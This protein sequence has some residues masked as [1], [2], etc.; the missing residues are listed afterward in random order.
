MPT[1]ICSEGRR[2]VEAGDGRAG[3]CDRSVQRRSMI[4][5]PLAVLSAPA[6]PAAQARGRLQLRQRAGARG[7][8]QR[9]SARPAQTPGP[10]GG[11]RRRLPWRPTC[12]SA[13]RSDAEEQWR[14]MAL[15]GPSYL[16]PTPPTRVERLPGRSWSEVQCQLKLVAVRG[17]GRAPTWEPPLSALGSALSASMRARVLP[18]PA[19]LPPCSL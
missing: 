10:G 14:A 13:I 18:L 11:L 4:K 9:P 1:P 3:A 17:Q 15:L 5:K 7:R 6:P 12:A 2:R 19:L 16:P 8:R